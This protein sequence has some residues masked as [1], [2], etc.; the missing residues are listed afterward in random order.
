MLIIIEESGKY[1]EGK[2]PDLEQDAAAFD[3]VLGKFQLLLKEKPDIEVS[4]GTLVTWSSDRGAH[5]Y[6]TW[7]AAALAALANEPSVQ[8][9]SS[10]RGTSSGQVAPG[11]VVRTTDTALTGVLDRRSDEEVRALKF[12]N[13]GQTAA[14]VL[15]LLEERISELHDLRAKQAA[16]PEHFNS[17]NREGLRVPLAQLPAPGN[18]LFVDCSFQDVHTFLLEVHSDKRRYLV[19]GYQG[20]YLASWWQGTDPAGLVLTKPDKEATRKLAQ[21]AKNSLEAVGKHKEA[22]TKLEEADRKFEVDLKKYNESVAAVTLA[23]S[24]YG[25][26]QPVAE[27]AMD[28]FIDNLVAAFASGTWEGFAKGWLLLPFCPTAEESDSLK[29]RGS[30]P[31][32]QLSRYEVKD[33]GSEGSISATVIPPQVSDYVKIA[34]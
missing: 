29:L 4:F 22:A 3:Y 19:Q 1:P 32:M 18:V 9:Q 21:Q 27:D 30:S 12:A 25:N 10:Q 6:P 24:V 2:V 31:R 16:K 20:A 17:A 8:S 14:A 28:K 33:S 23:R 5:K 7:A 11:Q 15:D 26:R 13:C 34:K